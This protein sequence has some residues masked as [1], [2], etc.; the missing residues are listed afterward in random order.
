MLLVKK[1]GDARFIAQSP[2]L[3]LLALSVAAD[4]LG[5][6]P[7]CVACGGAAGVLP[8]AL[9]PIGVLWSSVPVPAHVVL[10]M[11]HLQNMDRMAIP[12]CCRIPMGV[13]SGNTRRVGLVQAFAASMARLTNKRDAVTGASWALQRHAYCAR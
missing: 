9:Q 2:L 1:V 8:S 7:C 12:W 11:V 4:F 3:A 5:K 6:M 10:A 13:E